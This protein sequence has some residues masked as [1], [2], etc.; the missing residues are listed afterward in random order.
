MEQV[1]TIG[2]MSAIAST[3][4]ATIII[5]LRFL[6]MDITLVSS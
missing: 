2:I 1:L 3:A 5:T 6:K 4:A